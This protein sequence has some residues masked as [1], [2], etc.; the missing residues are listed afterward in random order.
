MSHAPVGTPAPDFSLPP[1]PGPDRVT[2]AELRGRPVVLLFFPLAFS[3]A[4]TEEM[5]T[6]AED[7][8]RW[9]E[10]GATVLGIS[11][12][13]PFVTRKFAQE[14]G[15]PFPLLSDFNKDAA[16]AYGVLDPDYYGLL[17]VAK[18]AAFVV[19]REGRIAYA[20][21]TEDSSVLPPFDEIRAAVARTAQS[22][23]K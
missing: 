6:V 21:V 11:V 8:S 3:E 19:D 13:S 2:L 7:W 9:Q 22:P 5:C 4:C 12:D 20:W 14:T 10:I 15:V 17:G 18:R 1:Q 16:S 23:T